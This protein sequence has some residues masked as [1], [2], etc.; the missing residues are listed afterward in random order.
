MHQ[1]AA[2][3][4][5]HVSIFN[6]C[7]TPPGHTY[8][9]DK[10]GYGRVHPSTFFI[11]V[12]CTKHITNSVN[13]PST[14]YNYEYESTYSCV[15]TREFR[16]TVLLSWE[17]IVYTINVLG[18]VHEPPNPRRAGACGWQGS[19]PA[20]LVGA[21]IARSVPCEPHGLNVSHAHDPSMHRKP[22]ILN[23]AYAK[24]VKLNPTISTQERGVE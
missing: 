19:Q 9:K 7:M 13:I 6:S 21:W 24:T 15:Y 5:V 8:R 12:A 23:R 11:I 18:T 17:T 16:C 2:A 1:R 22:G 3:L 14:R 20:I 10:L 4:E